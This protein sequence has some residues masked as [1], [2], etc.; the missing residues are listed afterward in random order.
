MAGLERDEIRLGP[1]ALV[2]R[3]QRK[4]ERNKSGVS[5]GPLSFAWGC[6]R[7]FLSRPCRAP[8]KGRYAGSLSPQNFG[9]RFSENALMPSLISAPR[10]LS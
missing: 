5:R 1:L 4:T 7:D 10:M 6:F 8:P 9:G 3:T 2:P